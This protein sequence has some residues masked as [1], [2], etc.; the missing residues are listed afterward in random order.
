LRTFILPEPSVIALVMIG[1][2]ALIVRQ[3]R[4]LRRPRDVRVPRS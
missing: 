1:A 4:R 2:L 3:I